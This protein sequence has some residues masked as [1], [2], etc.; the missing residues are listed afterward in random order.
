MSNKFEF[1]IGEDKYD[2]LPKQFSVNTF[3]DFVGQVLKSKSKSKGKNI[4][5]F[6]L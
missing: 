6:C 3:D 5:F 1:S 2:N 4:F